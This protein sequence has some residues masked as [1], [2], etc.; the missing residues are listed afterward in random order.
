MGIPSFH[1]RK[2][3]QKL[4]QFSGVIFA[5]LGDMATFATFAIVFPLGRKNDDLLNCF[6]SDFYELRSQTLFWFSSS[7]NSHFC[8]CFLHP[9]S[10]TYPNEN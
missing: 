2:F 1:L 8:C 3:H 7:P 6:F 5:W 10:M 9:I 4:D